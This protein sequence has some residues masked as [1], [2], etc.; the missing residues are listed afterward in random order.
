MANISLNSALQNRQADSMA[1]SFDLGAGNAV[2]EVYDGA[3][4]TDANTAL[5]A[6]T[7][8]ASV[9][10]ASPAFGASTGGTA[11]KNGTWEDLDV[12]ASGTAAWFRIR[13]SD[14][15]Y[16]L[17]GD[18]TGTSG[19]GDIEVDDVSFVAGGTFTVTSFDIAQPA[20]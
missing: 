8:L 2:L 13:D 15:T 4:P 3:I 1:D 16:V 19:G 10:I 7:L 18:V 17:Q 12:D 20:A 11:P 9:S 14:S 5:G 6:Q